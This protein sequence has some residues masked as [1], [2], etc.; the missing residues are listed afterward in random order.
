MLVVWK[1]KKFIN[2]IVGTSQHGQAKF[3][4]DVVIAMRPVIGS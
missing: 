3:S 4:K 1:K 2:A